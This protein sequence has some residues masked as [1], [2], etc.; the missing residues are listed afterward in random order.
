MSGLEIVYP[1]DGIYSSKHQEHCFRLPKQLVKLF[2]SWLL[3]L[4]QHVL[5]SLYKKI[6]LLL[7]FSLPELNALAFVFIR[8][9]VSNFL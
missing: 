8:D 7:L 1:Y 9:L 3:V 4:S 5:I 6:F 2:L